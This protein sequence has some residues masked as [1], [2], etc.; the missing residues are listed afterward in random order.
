MKNIYLTGFMGCGKTTIGKTLAKQI[1]KGFLDLDRHISAM[2]QR[3]I[4][5]IF[6][7]DGEE[8]FR[9]LESIYLGEVSEKQNLV[10]ALGG[11]TILNPFNADLCKSTGLVIFL[12][13]DFETTYERIK[14]S[15][16]PLV[17]NNTKEQLEKF[18]N[19]RFPI[20]DKNSN[21]SIDADDSP[22]QI[23]KEIKRNLK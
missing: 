20:Y 18:F 23:I 5:E 11:G 1:G 15:T 2:E 17:Q 4:P 10:V 6:S 9:E 16:R 8:K 3:E 21:F 13:L 22:F 19:G 7:T 12:K 14:D